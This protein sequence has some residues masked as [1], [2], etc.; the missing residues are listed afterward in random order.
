MYS[1]HN[2][3]CK[4]PC[5]Y[6]EKIFVPHHNIF[7]FQIIRAHSGFLASANGHWQCSATFSQIPLLK[8][9]WNYPKK[10]KYNV[11]IK[12]DKYNIFIKTRIPRN[13]MSHLLCTFRLGTHESISMTHILVKSIGKFMRYCLFYIFAILVMVEVAILDGQFV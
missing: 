3:L 1:L 7:M 12:T 11:F 13:A 2:R 4:G 5:G 9:T 6:C 10:I 8:L